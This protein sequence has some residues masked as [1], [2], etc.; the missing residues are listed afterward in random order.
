MAIVKD[1]FLGDHELQNIRLLRKWVSSPNTLVHGLCKLD[2]LVVPVDLA[3]KM[4]GKPITFEEITTSCEVKYAA[5]TSLCS[6]ACMQASKIALF[7]MWKQVDCC[8]YLAFSLCG[9]LLTILQYMR[10]GPRVSPP[11]DIDLHPEFFIRLL[12]TISVGDSHWL[13]YDP[14]VTDMVIGNC[15]CKQVTLHGNRV[16]FPADGDIKPVEVT[17]FT[18]I[19]PIFC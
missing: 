13:G 3:D 4:A 9:S 11:V 15:Q 14:W 1:K 2:L 19:H 16:A 12:L 10:G 18:L 17:T 7:C 8:Y 6:G 5:S